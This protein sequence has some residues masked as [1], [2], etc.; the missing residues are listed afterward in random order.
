MTDE[1]P[2]QA[3]R[4]PPPPVAP[5]GFAQNPPQ[6]PPSATPPYQVPPYPPQPYGYAVGPVD[7]PGGYGPP[8]GNHMGLSI[9]ALVVGVL[10]GGI[11]TIVTGIV[12]VVMASQVDGK[13]R[14]GDF[15]GAESSARKAKG[16][17][18]A[19]YIVSAIVLVLV[20]LFF[21]FVGLEANY[22]R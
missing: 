16:W 5:A 1:Y 9:G 21:A 14:A 13:W 15:A 4:P 17:A 11:I 2:P 12:A 18:V 10:V 22:V 8:P 7:S 19:T 6:P 3:D 20:V